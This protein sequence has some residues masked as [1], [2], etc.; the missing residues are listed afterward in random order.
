MSNEAESE[1][2]RDTNVLREERIEKLSELREKGLDPY[3]HS[4][5]RTH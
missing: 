2:T 4:Y 1:S 3:P 5:E